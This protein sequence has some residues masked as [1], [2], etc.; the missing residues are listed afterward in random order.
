[1]YLM[2]QHIGLLLYEGQVLGLVINGIIRKMSGAGKA[3]EKVIRMLE[4]TRYLQFLS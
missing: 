4:D 1:M 2:V 3:H